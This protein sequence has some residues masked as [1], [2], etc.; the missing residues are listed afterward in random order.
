M[1]A[2]PVG[3]A[4]RIQ[5]LEREL[6]RALHH[7]HRDPLTGLL[8][9]RGLAQAF[10]LLGSQRSLDG[11]SLCCVYLD[12]DDFKQV[13]DR[14]GH[15]IGDACLQHF[16]HVLMATLRR[17]D[18]VARVGGDEFV[19]LLP[20]VSGHEAAALVYRV[21]EALVRRPARGDMRL[22]FCAGLTEVGPQE[23]LELALARADR[24]LLETKDGPKNRTIFS[25]SLVHAGRPP[26]HLKG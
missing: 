3:A 5:E 26:L 2:D 25:G 17:E 15:V 9:R 12:L 19:V 4:R 11:G 21:K 10:E 16:A 24:G 8:N 23:S 20:Q 18:V 14:L 1:H 7:M 6:K 22:E 13:N